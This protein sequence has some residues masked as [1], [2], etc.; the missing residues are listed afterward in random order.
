MKRVM[1]TSVVI[2]LVIGS[3]VAH[4]QRNGMRRGR[5]SGAR[6]A[7]QQGGAN[8]QR[9]SQFQSTPRGLGRGNQR[10]QSAIGRTST[11]PLSA[12]EMTDLIY[13]RQEEQLARDVYLALGEKWNLPIFANIARSESRHMNA[14]AGLLAKYNI[15]GPVSRDV[16]GQFADAKLAKLYGTLVATGLKSE[17]DAIRVGIQIEK[18]DIADLNSDLSTT[19]HSDIRSVY[20][21]LLRGSQNH[22][23]AFTSKLN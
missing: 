13:M 10:G 12:D 17:A 20:Q 23:R 16:R 19:T 5:S 8:S 2:A 3:Q 9:S 22:L 11:T 6:S 14:I 15:P 7:F 1:L 21:K 4:A 18:L